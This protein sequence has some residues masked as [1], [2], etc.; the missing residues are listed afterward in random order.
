MCVYS[1]RCIHGNGFWHV[2]IPS[3]Y[4]ERTRDFETISYISKPLLLLRIKKQTKIISYETQQLWRH[5]LHDQK[6]FFSELTRSIMITNFVSPAITY[7][8]NYTFRSF[9]AT[10]LSNF[11]D[12]YPWYLYTRDA[13]RLESRERHWQ[14]LQRYAQ[15]RQ[16][17]K[18][19]CC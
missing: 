6:M 15:S 9:L 13:M 11:F 2:C 3:L 19:D 16:I 1:I 8:L 5:S 7:I 18:R 12:R 10:L 17:W 14:S 4:L